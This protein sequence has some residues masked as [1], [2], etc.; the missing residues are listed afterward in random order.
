MESYSLSLKFFVSVRGQVLIEGLVF[1]IFILSFLLTVQ[2]F[3]S[4]AREE[5]QKQRL[6]LKRSK[7]VKKDNWHQELFKSSEKSKSW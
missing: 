7:P 4:V 3:Q 6:S 1:M 5:I 2:F